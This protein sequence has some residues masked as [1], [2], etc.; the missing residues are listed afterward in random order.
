MNPPPGLHAWTVHRS[1]GKVGPSTTLGRCVTDRDL[2]KRRVHELVQHHAAA[3]IDV[4][5]DILDHPETGFREE[6]TAGLVAQWFDGLGLQHRDGLAI[7]G[8]RADLTGGEPGRT[9]A[10]MG[11]LDSLI[12]P[13]HPHAAKGT[14]FAH[15][16]GHHA[17]IGMVL[18]VAAA[19]AEPEV[20]EQL[21]GNVALMA[22]PAEEYIE[23]SYRQGLVADGR[24]EFMGGKAELVRL[25]VFDDVDICMLTHSSSTSDEGLLAYG[26]VN[27]GAIAKEARFIGVQAHAGSSPHLGVN[28]L[29][30]AMLAMAAINANR[31]TFQD[32]DSIR[33][34]PIVT[35][36]GDV[37]N[38]VPADVRMEMF[39][40]GR[41]LDAIAE[42]DRKVER[43]LRAGGLAVGAKVEVTTYSAYLPLRQDPALS[44][45]YRLNAARVVGEEN[46]SVARPR[47][48]STDMGD[49]SHI[50]PTIQ[51]N[52]KGA[53]GIVHGADFLITDYDLAVTS[54]AAAMA[55]TVVDL[56]GEDGEAQRIVDGFTPAL[57]KE[58]YL[59]LQRGFNRRVTYED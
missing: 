13:G 30:A 59:E 11:E 9:V 22:V 8:V 20:R 35:K 28:A 2:L 54:P 43:S 23:L 45:V 18:A 47:G 52:A 40:R 41:T 12:V 34:H 48:S 44:D 32:P 42:A 26:S 7:T 49:L 6:R 58:A 24:I 39:V 55:M 51:P 57:S 25:G 53:K 33:V 31:E 37:V 14:N 3:A 4:A 46:V 36:G 5:R 1:Q 16:C 21:H 29:Q 19:L 17:Q 27:N 38:A 10:V 56:L 50:M 15:A